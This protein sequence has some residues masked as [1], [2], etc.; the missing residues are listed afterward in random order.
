[1]NLEVRFM[2]GKRSAA[3]LAA[4]ILG[5]LAFTA[6]AATN[7]LLGWSATGLHETDGSDFSV[8]LIAPPYSTIHAQLVI[9][10]LL[11]TNPAGYTVTYEAVADSKGSINSTSAGKGNFYQYAQKLFGQA[12]AADQGLSGFGMPGTSNV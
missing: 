3:A 5:F 11:V 12:L 10:G 4:V 8:Y 2:V 9:G 1:M 7:A 6:S